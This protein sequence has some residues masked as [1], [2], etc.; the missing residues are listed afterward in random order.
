M[1]MHL[2]IL[3][4]LNKEAR[5]KRL[6]PRLAKTFQNLENVIYENMIMA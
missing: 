6:S 1:P 2:K 5:S 4:K 3:G